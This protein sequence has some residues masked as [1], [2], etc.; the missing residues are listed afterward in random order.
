MFIVI[1]ELDF[2]SGLFHEYKNQKNSIH[3]KYKGCL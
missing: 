1:V 2:L 3:V